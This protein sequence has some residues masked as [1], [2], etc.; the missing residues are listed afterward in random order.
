MICVTRKD[1]TFR[2]NMSIH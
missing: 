2:I 1:I